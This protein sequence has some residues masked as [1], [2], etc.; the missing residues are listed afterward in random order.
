VDTPL[1]RTVLNTAEEVVHQQVAPTDNFFDLGGDSLTFIDFAM[2]LEELLGIEVDMDML[3]DA[4][5]FAEFSQ[6]LQKQEDG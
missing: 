5:D 1:L 2:R 4:A 6:L 3:V